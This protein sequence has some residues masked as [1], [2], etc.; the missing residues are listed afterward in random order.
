[1]SETNS[2]AEML[3]II[4]PADRQAVIDDLARIAAGVQKTH[5]MYYRWITRNSDIV[6]IS[7]RGRVIY[8][9]V[10][11]PAIMVGRVS[12]ETLRHLYNP[13]TGL[14]NKEKLKDD[15]A[16]LLPKKA[17]YLMLLDIDGLASINL[18][19]GRDYGDNL[20]KEIAHLLESHEYVSDA[21][22]VD[23]KN[24]A[25]VVNSRND[26]RVRSVYRH[27]KNA[28]SEKCTFTASAVPI[29]NE[30][31]MDSSH[32]LDS[33]NITLKKAKKVTG[34][35][36]EFFSMEEI[37]QRIES[38]ALLEDL[39]ESIQK[40][41]LG[42]KINYQPQ[43]DANTFQLYGVE[44]LIRYTSPTRG[45]MYPDQFIPILEQ[46][47]LINKVGLWVLE[48][49]LL[50]CKQ[51]RQFLPELRVSVNFSSTQFADRYL[52]E[53]IVNILNRTE[54]PGSA[55]TI[56]ITE[57]VRL[58]D[59]E[60]FANH[61]KTLKGYGI[62]FAVDDFGTGYSNLAYL[63]QLDIDEIKI[64]RIF[65]SDLT[66]NTYNYNLIHNVISFAKANDIRICCEGVESASELMVLSE[67][68]PDLMQGYF[69]AKPATAQ[70]IYNAFMDSSA[71]EYKQR[72]NF[73]SLLK[74]SFPELQQ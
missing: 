47:Q 34:N 73:I 32:L 61:M 29:D 10:G 44:A 53:R 39:S 51:W 23:H 55:L 26:N 60:V 62:Q 4:H 46:S 5:N 1:G 71:V 19:H 42:F 38:L 64:D 41:Y 7:C 33:I 9:E 14:W 66:E 40:G 67:L 18:A 50:Q 8:D 31:F 69:F 57:S 24:F 58:H 65:V 2:T 16:A 37:Q 74:M 11:N 72:T 59:D 63:K 35:R 3:E 48:N 70:C 13:L 52:A 17:G 22:H 28:M 45:K 56:E 27:I 43:L 20:L 30:I 25:V 36:L 54:M 68:N 21:Y 12:E 49:A 6:W 15:L